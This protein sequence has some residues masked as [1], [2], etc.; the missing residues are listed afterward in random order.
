LLPIAWFIQ[1]KDA[2]M[3]VRV[4][5]DNN[6]TGSEALSSHV[7]GVVEDVLGR[8]SQRLT[9]IEVHLADE[10]S[11]AK[12]GENDKR[13]TMEARPRGLKPIAV[14]EQ[15]ATVDQAVD[16][17][18]DTLAKTLDRTLGRLEDRKRPSYGADGR[19]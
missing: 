14:T 3:Q 16:A 10:N 8:F 11:R 4:A 18:A 12:S 6:I 9:R 15:A 5:T 13:C 19:A 1:T 17:A 2:A 7:E